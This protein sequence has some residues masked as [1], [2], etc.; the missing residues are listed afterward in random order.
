MWPCPTEVRVACSAPPANSA[1]AARALLDVWCARRRVGHGP[2]SFRVHTLCDQSLELLSCRFQIAWMGDSEP[3]IGC[4]VNAHAGFT[5]LYR[6][7][8]NTRQT[9]LGG[10]GVFFVVGAD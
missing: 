3:A 5:G 4:R 9:E 2:K 6:L 1:R 7:E 8:N 10:E